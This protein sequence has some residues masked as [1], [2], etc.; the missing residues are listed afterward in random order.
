MMYKSHLVVSVSADQKIRFWDF[1]VTAS[2]QPVFTLYGD[3]DRLDSLS[4]I[5]TTED[6]NWLITGDTTGNMKMWDL[7][8]HK[9]RVDLTSDNIREV[10]FIQVHRRVINCINIVEISHGEDGEKEKFI[11]S[12]ANDHN[13]QLTRFSD[14]VQIGQ[15]GQDSMWNIHDLSAFK[16]RIPRFTRSWI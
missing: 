3:H 14:G 16:Y 6:N 10:W 8:D 4:T 15:F 9:F 11:V 1:D 13:I 7:T 12:S 5:A 2:R